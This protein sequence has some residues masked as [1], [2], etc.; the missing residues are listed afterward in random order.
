MSSVRLVYHR[1]PDR[2]DVF[3]QEVLH[4][5]RGCHVT[6]LERATLERPMQVNGRTI[7]EDGAPIVWFTFEGAWHDIGRFHNAAG[8]F[9]GYYA[10]AIRPVTMHDAE[11]WECTDLYLDV[12]LG[13]DGAVIVDDDELDV[14]LREGW[15]D[16]PT[17]DRARV[18][19]AQIVAAAAAGTWPP[20]IAREWTIEH[21]N[22]NK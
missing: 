22:L 21:A 3:Q 7:L 1:G 16:A 11:N 18:E 17:A 13:P 2:T 12:W 14:A 20:A 8:V 5:E 9:T 4:V 6:L 10:N 19:A 15:I